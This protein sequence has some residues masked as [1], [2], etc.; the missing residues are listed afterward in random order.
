[1]NPMNQ[2]IVNYH[3]IREQGDRGIHPCTIERFREQVRSLLRTHE[4]VSV[5]ELYAI[6]ARREPGK[7]FALTFDDGLAEHYRVAFPLLREHRIPGT[8][9]VL[10]MPLAERRM[11][12]SHALHVLLSRRSTEELIAML[13]RHARGA[14]RVDRREP[15]NP[16]RRFDDVLTANLKETL[17]RMPLAERLGFIRYALASVVPDEAAFVKAFFMDADEVREMDQA[18]MT[19]GAHTMSHAALDTLGAAEQEQEI[20]RGNA[21][22]AAVLGRKSAMFSYPHGRFTEETAHILAAEGF[23]YGVTLE[24]RDLSAADDPLRIPRYDTNDMEGGAE[25]TP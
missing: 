14:V 15:M 20:R 24:V 13:E 6:A 18:G 17:I 11:P 2:G 23:R 16:K 8:F 3:Y 1:M 4:P 12:P 19:I 22:L 7:F 5:E 21:A 25:R 9:F 10:G